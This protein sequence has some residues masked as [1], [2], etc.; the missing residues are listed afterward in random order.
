MLLRVIRYMGGYLRIRVKGS[1]AE[2]FLN[3][4]GHRGIFLWD[5]R[6]AR[7]SYEMNISIKGFRKLKPIIRKTGTKVVIIERFGLPFFLQKYRRRKVFFAGALLCLGLIYAFSG[8]LWNIEIEGNLTHTDETLLEFL[9]T[10]DIQ[11]GMRIQ[12]VD[13]AQIVRDIRREYNDII[14]VSASIQGTRLYIQ[15]KENEDLIQ[16]KE[17]KE[18]T[19]ETAKDLVAE[20][21]CTI[22]SMI[23]RKGVA[24][25][26]PGDQ[27][28]KGDILVSGQVPVDND[29]KE[30]I[31]FQYHQSDAD[32]VARTTLSYEAEMPVHYEI[33]E[34]SGIEK[35]EYFITFGKY[36][37][38]LGGVRN[39]YERAET[40]SRQ[41]QARLFGNFYLP[42]TFGERRA[43]PY[44]PRDA[45]HSEE[46]IQQ[47]LSQDFSLYCQDLEKKGVEIIENNVKIYTG[48]KTAAAKGNLEVLMP[49]GEEKP[50]KLIQLPEKEEQSGEEIDGNDGSSH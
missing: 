15:V 9:K 40:F 1:F 20:R 14:W 23:V 2:R 30:T 8:F 26:K 7:D 43:V 50:S 31:G 27:V 32:I 47:T 6:P 4:C 46:E 22:T 12:D 28:K 35:T 41:Y 38:C 44:T 36:R 34:D 16:S 3:A 33:Y 13:C 37:F 5:I 25:V 21:D 42:I 11:N 48:P 24:Q 39:D 17:T 18:N 10:T 45:V 49:V 29:A 19:A